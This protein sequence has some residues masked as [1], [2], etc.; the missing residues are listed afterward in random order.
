MIHL[1]RIRQCCSV[2][3]LLACTKSGPGPE[4]KP[5]SGVEAPKNKSVR[6]RTEICS[7]PREQTP[8]FCKDPSA[9]C[10]VDAMR[11]LISIARGPGMS[12]WN[13]PE[14]HLSLDPPP[15]PLPRASILETNR[16]WVTLSRDEMTRA[17]AWL[18]T[19]SGGTADHRLMT[20]RLAITPP[21]ERRVSVN[22]I[23]CALQELI[24]LVAGNTRAVS[25]VEAYM[26]RLRDAT[27]PMKPKQ[28]N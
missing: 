20:V 17:Y 13:V 22:E 9:S 23:D 25:S 11:A 16:T 27:P 5:E 18:G 19:I 6:E 14:L 24:P 1:V 12:G 28:R 7:R 4:V 15:P 2:A 8:W 21:Q 26:K 10:E 3:M